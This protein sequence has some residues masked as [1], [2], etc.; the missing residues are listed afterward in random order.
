MVSELCHRF[1]QVPSRLYVQILEL[2][3]KFKALKGAS[4]SLRNHKR[5]PQLNRCCKRNPFILFLPLSLP[6]KPTLPSV[7]LYV[8]TRPNY[9]QSLSPKTKFVY[10]SKIPFDGSRSSKIVKGSVRQ[11]II[12]HPLSLP[13]CFVYAATTVDLLS[14]I[15]H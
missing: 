13:Y 9:S 10:S 8:H 12:C 6:T 7:Y 5:K 14:C 2:P 3:R 15:Q 1:A 4:K 11:N